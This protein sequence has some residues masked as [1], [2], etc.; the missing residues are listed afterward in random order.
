MKDIVYIEGVIS[1][2]DIPDLDGDT[3]TKADIRKMYANMK[4]LKVDMNHDGK[5]L[6]DTY[7]NAYITDV[8]KTVAGESV[9][10]G[11]LVA[12]IKTSNPTVIGNLKANT[13]KGLSLMTS[14]KTNCPVCSENLSLEGGSVD[15]NDITS[16]ECLAPQFVSLVKYPANNYSMDVYNYDKFINKEESV[17]D[18]SLDELK[19]AL[20]IVKNTDVNLMDEMQK[21]E[22]KEEPVVEQ[23]EESATEKEVTVIKEVI[24]YDVLAKVVK[25]AIAYYEETKV[26][27][28]TKEEV[29]PEEAEVKK[30]KA[31]VKE[32]E[33]APAQKEIVKEGKV[34]S[35]FGLPVE[36]I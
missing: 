10:E 13:W 5:P 23:Q 4:N 7:V 19:K 6:R 15:Y 36:T 21:K 26:E 28:E 29:V 8:T 9:P 22:Q 2:P 1:V 14:V 20:R 11:S 24:D 34:D 25:E 35:V 17:M 31:V 18:F 3:L 27:K 16:K 33:K 30:E 12:E 32:M